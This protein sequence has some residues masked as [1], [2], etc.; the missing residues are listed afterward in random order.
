MDTDW[1]AK[2]V[3]VCS[4]LGVRPFPAPD[5]LKVGVSRSVTTG[6][7][8]LNGLRIAPEADTTGWYIWAGEWSDAPDFFVPLHAHHLVNWCPSV[9]PYLQLPPGWRSLIALDHEEDRKSV[10]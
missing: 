8:P 7:Q 2:Q 1:I 4:R 10:V 5:E 6:V 9:L 3:E